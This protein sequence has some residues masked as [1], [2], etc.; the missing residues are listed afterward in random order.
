MSTQ[1]IVL[2]RATTNAFNPQSAF[3][4]LAANFGVPLY[5]QG[6]EM[7]IINAFLYY[8]WPNISANLNNNTLSYKDPSGTSFNVIFP[9]G[10]YEISDIQGYLELQM[11]QNGHYLLNNTGTEVYFIQL[12]ANPVY[13]CVTL[14]CTPVPSSLPSGWTNPAG[15]DLSG[16]TFQFIIPDPVNPNAGPN[17][18]DPINSSMSKVLGFQSGAYPATSQTTIYMINGQYAPQ[19]SM[20]NNI[21]ITSS[22]VN[23]PT[24]P[25]YASVVTQF[26]PTGSSGSEINYTPQLLIWKPIADGLYNNII[27]TFTNENLIPLNILDPESNMI[28]ILRKRLVS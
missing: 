17:G 28:L 12:V 7:S 25:N 20:V 14:T 26:P 2:N 4:V 9:D 15:L 11:K 18:T 1:T 24:Q 23:D 3:N 5:F 13:Y 10:I 19:I 22:L 21:A 16:K 6:Y 27:C 8:S